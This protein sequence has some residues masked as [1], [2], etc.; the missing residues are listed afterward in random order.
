MLSHT[1]PIKHKGL[2]QRRRAEV[3]GALPKHATSEK[4]EVLKCRW[5]SVVCT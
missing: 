2:L 3:E 5:I 4:Q 1:W